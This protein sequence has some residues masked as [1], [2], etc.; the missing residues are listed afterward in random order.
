[1][2]IP[3]SDI[4]ASPELPPVLQLHKH[5]AAVTFPDGICCVII[6]HPNRA[7]ILQSL[8]PSASSINS[9]SSSPIF[10]ERNQAK[11]TH[12]VVM[13]SVE[14]QKLGMADDTFI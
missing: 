9:A 12:E 13:K 2:C 14:F 10:K 7:G 6:P 4:A 1:M 11:S 5:P 3:N 8:E